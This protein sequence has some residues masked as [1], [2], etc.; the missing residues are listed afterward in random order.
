VHHKYGKLKGNQG[1]PISQGLF[2]LCGLLEQA[3]K[4]LFPKVGIGGEGMLCLVAWGGATYIHALQ[5]G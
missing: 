2:S 5:V 4:A 3:N 1:I